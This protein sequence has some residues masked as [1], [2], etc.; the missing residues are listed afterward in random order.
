[1]ILAHWLYSEDHAQ[2]VIRARAIAQGHPDPA[3][4]SDCSGDRA[5]RDAESYDEE[6]A[7]EEESDLTDMSSSS[8][9]SFSYS[10]SQQSDH[11]VSSMHW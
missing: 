8:A 4:P 10:A 6:P 9:L 7:A 1:M 11:Q 5:P 2:L 3:L